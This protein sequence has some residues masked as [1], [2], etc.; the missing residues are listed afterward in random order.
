[1]TTRSFKGN[2]PTA[3]S[4]CDEK[5]DFRNIAYVLS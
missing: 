4:E 5:L 3:T 2:V 1:M